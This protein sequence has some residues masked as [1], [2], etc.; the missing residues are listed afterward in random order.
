LKLHNKQLGGGYTAGRVYLYIG[1]SGGGKSMLHLNQVR[2]FLTCNP[3][4]VAYN[5]RLTPVVLYVTLENDIDE[6]P[7]KYMNYELNDK[8]GSDEFS[9]AEDI[10]EE[11][12][13]S[14]DILNIEDLFDAG[15]LEEIEE[16]ENGRLDLEDDL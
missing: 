3:N 6:N 13:E 10:E 12:D 15:C 9:S 14:N 7:L 8:L 11:E 5:P 1:P 4:M 16:D 2:W